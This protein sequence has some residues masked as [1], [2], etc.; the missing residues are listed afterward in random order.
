MAAREDPIPAHRRWI[1]AAEFL[2][3]AAVV[4]AHNVY[5]TIPNEVPIL[6]VAGLL[7]SRL[8]LGRWR[9]PGLGCPSSWRRTVLIALA[10]AAVRLLLGEFVI[11]PLGTLVWPPPALPAG[12]SE[13]TGNPTKALLALV[14]V[15]TFAAFGEEFAYRGYLQ[16][17]FAEAGGRSGLA[18]WVGV[19]AVAVLF[20]IGHYYKGPVGVIDSGVAGL[21]L[22]AAYLL[23]GQ[24]LWAPVLAHGLID[25]YGVVVLCFGW[26]S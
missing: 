16:S 11:E 13:I 10:A 26:A 17:R 7:S 19:V 20:G 5:K 1:A 8:S 24:N 18:H 14:L 3:G 2:V 21:I 4:V 6:V 12:A 25:T 22:G 23:S 9:V 15:W